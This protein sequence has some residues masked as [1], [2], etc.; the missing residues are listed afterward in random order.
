MASARAG[1]ACTAYWETVVPLLSNKRFVK[2]FRLGRKAFQ[3]LVDELQETLYKKDTT[4]RKAIPVPKRIAIALYYMK[5][6]Q[7]A[8]E[9]A[10]TFGVG[11]STVH[12]LLHEFCQAVNQKNAPKVCRLS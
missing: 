12:M 3:I 4:F 5:S 7:T 10:D 9:V 2:K 11:E 1:K 8:E 6:N